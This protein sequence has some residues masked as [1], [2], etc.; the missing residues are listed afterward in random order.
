[1]ITQDELL[2]VLSGNKRYDYSHFIKSGSKSFSDLLINR[3]LNGKGRDYVIEKIKA[4]LEVAIIN[5]VKLF[6]KVFGHVT[7]ENTAKHNT[8]VILDLRDEFFEHYVGGKKPLMESAWELLAFEI[9][10]DDG[11]YGWL[12]NWL[13]KRLG[14]ER[15]AGNWVDY[16]D[17]Y[18][19][20]GCWK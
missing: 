2:K 8:H 18:M 12:F 10:H 6:V 15:E 19:Q 17:E 5:S 7:K 20:K 4:P 13:M 3:T 1:M 11:H 14:E 16:P 9:E